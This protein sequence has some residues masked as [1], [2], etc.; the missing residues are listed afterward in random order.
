MFLVHQVIVYQDNG[1]TLNE[2]VTVTGPAS[3]VSWC[4]YNY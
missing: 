1:G 3:A 2:A 4:D